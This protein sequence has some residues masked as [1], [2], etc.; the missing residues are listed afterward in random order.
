M[1][2]L[3]G[4][5]VLGAALVAA[6]ALA[7]AQQTQDI[8]KYEYQSSCA[9]CHGDNGKGDGSLS[10]YYNKRAADLSV[11]QKNNNGVFSFD[12]VYEV[13]DGRQAVAAHGPSDMPVWGDAYSMRMQGYTSGFGTSKDLESFVRGRII[14][15]VG[16]IYTLQEK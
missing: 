16:Y 10:K 11:I 6:P 13:I 8:G 7:Y 15:L 5:A 2:Q 4:T 1:K 12:R 14:A 3:M 9:V